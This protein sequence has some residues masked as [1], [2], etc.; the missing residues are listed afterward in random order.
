MFEHAHWTQFP[1]THAAIN[2]QKTRKRSSKPRTR[3]DSAHLLV[4]R[5]G[6]RL[7]LEQVLS[8]CS[9]LTNFAPFSEWLEDTLQQMELLNLLYS[10]DSRS[11]GAM[12]LSIDMKGRLRL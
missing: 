3:Q 7:L 6:I 2:R 4:A 9:F 5:R 10:K 1:R 12:I 8:P 11:E